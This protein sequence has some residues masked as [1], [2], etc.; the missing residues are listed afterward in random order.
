MSHP[1]IQSATIDRGIR[2]LLN[3]ERHVISD[4]SFGWPVYV[5]TMRTF[6]GLL[7]QLEADYWQ[8]RFDARR[9]A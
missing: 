8:A 9:P 1:D 3:C 7:E 5:E 2:I 6:D 4:L